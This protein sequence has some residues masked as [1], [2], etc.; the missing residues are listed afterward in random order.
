MIISPPL[1]MAATLRASTKGLAEVDQARRKK[2]WSKLEKAWVD[3][4]PTSEATL[5]RFWAGLA[6]QTETFQK[7]CELVG[8]LDWESIAN[9]EKIDESPPQGYT[10]RLCFAI[11]GSIEEIDKNKLDAIVAL[12]RKLGGD[13][14]IEILDID[15]GSIKLILGGSPEA[16]SEIEALFR[17]GELTE[18]SGVLVQD[19]HFLEK[20]ELILLIQKNGGTAL[21]LV[22]ADLSGADLSGVDLSEADLQGTNLFGADLQGANLFG[23][24]L[25]RADLSRANLDEADLIGADL[26][27]ADLSEADLFGADLS[28]ADLSEANLSGADLSGANLR[29]VDVSR[30]DLGEANLNGARFENNLGLS[31][32]NK[33]EMKKRGAIFQDSPDSDVPSFAGR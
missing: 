25:S 2:G 33:L 13:A 23:A 3:L 32:L 16:L 4:A 5:R 10:K 17:S 21:N 28:G 14:T 20:D 1:T 30:A 18:V 26:R 29:E 31:E 6:I 19:V 9:F 7:I 8:I 12:L 27:E 11:A 22:G 15:E 24:D